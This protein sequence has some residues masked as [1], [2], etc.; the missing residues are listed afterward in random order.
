MGCAYFFEK[1]TTDINS[2]TGVFN[3]RLLQQAMEFK[4]HN[5]LALAK[6]TGISIYSIMQ[7]ADGLREPTQI[8]LLQ[9]GYALGFLP[10][11]F[12]CR[13]KKLDE[14]QLI[15][16]CGDGIRP[17][18][19]CGAVADYL[20]DQPIGDGKTCDLPLCNEHRHHIGAYDYCETHP[21]Y[22]VIVL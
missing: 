15:F 1:W 14:P 5:A 19:I 9:I 3:P 20:C 7:L 8:E 6:A 17:C 2:Q 10:T 18:H 11:F 21:Q 22:P 13:T 12:Y 16:V 4:G